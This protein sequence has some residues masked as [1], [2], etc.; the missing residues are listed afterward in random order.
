L[1]PQK[2]ETGDSLTLEMEWENKGVAP[3]YLLHPLALEFRPVAGDTSW[4]VE[5]D[6]DITQWL[7]G[8]VRV[9]PRVALPADLPPGEYEL[10][11]GMLDP[12]TRRPRIRFAI[13]GRSEDGWYRLSRI[14]IR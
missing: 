13:R 8:T 11:I 6:V 2:V 12:Y 4:V 14:Q 7:P 3:C 5:T 1:Y 9:Q 10:G